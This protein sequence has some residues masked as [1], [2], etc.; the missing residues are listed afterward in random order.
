MYYTRDWSHV[1]TLLSRRP[2][3]NPC[4]LES[5]NV[6]TAEI[7]A[8]R[9]QRQSKCLSCAMGKAVRIAALIHQASPTRFA[10]V[11]GLNGNPSD[12]LAAMQALSR[13]IRK[14]TK[15]EWCYVIEPDS[16]STST[17]AHAYVAPESVFDRGVWMRAANAQGLSVHEVPFLSNRKGAAYGLKGVL[18]WNCVPRDQP[19]REHER[20]ARSAIADHLFRNSGRFVH[21]S[22]AFF[23]D[24]QG[25]HRSLTDLVRGSCAEG[26]VSRYIT[27]PTSSRGQVVRRLLD[28]ELP[29]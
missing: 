20:K 16:H 4:F 5:L 11:R 14:R 21:H 28:G 2:C 9:C 6:E 8:L 1:A 10:T 18:G 22:R 27:Y 24:E 12:D 7:T 23:R 29:E 25:V 17:H 19:L 13:S 3:S 15:L 26:E